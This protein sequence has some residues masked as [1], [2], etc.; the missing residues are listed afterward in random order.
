MSLYLLIIGCVSILGQ[1]IILRELSV[2]FYGVE[3]IYI[4]AMGIWLF[5]TGIGALIGRKAHI[6]SE[7]GIRFLFLFFSLVLPLD[8][9][10][11]RAIRL[12]FQGVTGTYLPFFQQLAGITI[13]M[14]PIGILLGLI[15]QWA[16]RLYVDEDQ[17]LA[18]AYAIESV[19]G[20]AGG[21]LSTLFLQFGI[22]N[23]TL[24]ILCSLGAVCASFVWQD[25]GM[26]HQT[27]YAEYTRAMAFL[28]LSLLLFSSVR[29]DHRMTRW[30]H[31]HLLESRDSPY[32][33]ITIEGRSGQF[34][35]FENDVLGFETQ[36][37]SAEALVHL[38]AIQHEHPRRVFIA[39]GGFEGILEEILKHLPDKV[40]DAELNR[41]LLRIIRKHLN[42]SYQ[43][44]FP[45]EIIRIHHTDPRVFLENA[46]G[47]DLILVGMPE[48]ASGQSNR[49]YTREYFEQCAK[50][51]APGGVLAFRLRSSENLWTRFLTY[52]NASIYQALTAAF[53]DV[54]VLPGTSN[55]I[56]AS[57]QTLIR[58]PD[59]LIERFNARQIKAKQISPPYIRYV[60]TNDRF[61]EIMDRLSATYAPPNTDVRPICYQY[62]SMIWLSKFIPR[63]INWDFSHVT[64]GW[65]TAW[66]VSI[67]ICLGGIFLVLRKRPG[68]KRVTLAALA[69]FTGMVLEMMLMLHYQVRNGVLFQDIGILLMAFM[70]GLAAG[71][72][73]I[74]KCFENASE[75]QLQ[76][77]PPWMGRGLLI[78]FGALNLLF[79]GLLT[80]GYPSGIDT[81][82]LLLFAAGFLVSGVFAFAS[83]SGVK[84][85]KSVISPLYAADLLG[86]CLGAVI[87]SLV[88]IPFFGMETSAILMA[89]L[90]LAAVLL[91]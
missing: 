42:P 6:P 66:Y 63:M 47:Y 58:D 10:F 56:L 2:A 62:S 20:L 69:G 7:R 13:A 35:V 14:L 33:R 43:K 37:T 78:G 24:A 18:M 32:S 9:A 77:L 88:L 22:Q 82:S 45:S 21:L 54:L 72:A 15:F 39:G 40:D 34:V 17:T 80:Y 31:P 27:S 67:F 28:A 89:M 68:A 5:G 38:A 87:G 50:S 25:R 73:V 26:E 79:I 44:W 41:V 65:R 76:F 49:F 91:I 55:I 71:A 52:R 11:I 8:I 46:K 84:Y 83:L 81:A 75:A 23:F 3:L 1:V 85:Q 61:F 57:D 19:G 29:V 74:T 53:R 70:A 90:S 30:T 36:S 86:G 51:L 60:Y 12:L 64:G 16:A 4:L 59:K 48:P